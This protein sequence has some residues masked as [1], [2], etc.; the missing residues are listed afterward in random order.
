M[1]SAMRRALGKADDQGGDEEVSNVRSDDGTLKH[2]YLISNVHIYGPAFE[3]V[4][5]ENKYTVHIEPG[6]S[7]STSL[8]AMKLEEDL[9]ILIEYRKTS[10][11]L[12]FNDEELAQKWATTLRTTAS[13]AKEYS[14]KIGQRTKRA[15]DLMSHRLVVPYQN[16]TDSHA[17]CMNIGMCAGID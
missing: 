9:G 11:I 3:T 2:V 8:H 17:L 6:S 4:G 7:D 10:V 5:N 1:K 12:I 14:K 13:E 16:K 15:C